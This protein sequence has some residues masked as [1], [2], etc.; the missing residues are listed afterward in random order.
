MDLRGRLTIKIISVIILFFFT[1]TFGGVFDIAY[2]VKDSSQ[3][4]ASGRQGNPVKQQ[5][6]PQKPE[7]KLQKAIEAIE[8]AI[9]DT[10]IDNDKKKNRLV[11]KKAEIE[12]LDKEI[13]KQFAETEKKLKEKGLP[14]EI[15]ERHYKF[16]RNYEDNLKELNTNLDAVNKHDAKSREFE[17]AIKKTKE[18]LAK[19]KLPSKHKRLDPNKLPHRTADPVFK[20]P[21]TKPE[22]FQKDSQKAKVAKGQSKPILVASSGSLD[23]LLGQRAYQG[24]PAPTMLAMANPPTSDDLAQTIEVQFT[25]AIKA[26]AAELNYNPVK[27][28]NW[29]RNNIEYVP[30]YGSI[31]GADMCLQTKQCND[32][33]T[34]SLLIALLRASGI[35]A[36]YVYGTIEL[37]IDK[38]KNWIGGFTDNNAAL[39]LIASGGIPIKGFTSGGSIASAQM[40]HVWVEAWIDYI[41][42]RGA[43]HKIGNTWIPLDAS[44]KQFT[45]KQGID[46]KSITG[47][48]PKS[49]IDGITASSTADPTTGSVTNVPTS[50]IQNQMDTMVNSLNNYI[51]T[52]MPDATVRDILGGKDIVQHNYRILPASLPFQ[53]VIADNRFSQAPNSLRHNIMITIEDP[54]GIDAPLSYSASLPQLSSKRLTLGYMP[55][56]AA[57]AQTLSTYGYY[58][59]PLYLVN[60]KPVLYIDGVAA[61]QGASLG[62]GDT[63]S[64]TITFSQPGRE[65]DSVMHLIAASTFASIGLDT[66]RIPLELLTDRKAKLD[67]TLALMGQQDVAVDDVIGEILNLHS[68]SYF[69]QVELMN[70]IA[71]QGKIAYAK[72]TLEMFITLSPNI[73]YLYGV[74]YSVAGL[75]MNVDAKRQ[76]VTAISLTGNNDEQRNFMLMT[77]QYAS[78]MEH[79][80]FEEFN[81]DAQGVSA[82][83]IISEAVKQGIPIY[84][85]TADNID[86]ILPRLQISSDALDD[87]KNAVA[88]GKKV[89]IP[90]KSLQY[91]DWSGDG[92]IIINPP[93]GAGAYM[94]AGGLSGGGLAT[95]TDVQ[96]GI[97]T[98]LRDISF[99]TLQTA[100]GQLLDEKIS[101]TELAG[102]LTTS[103][104]AVQKLM[105]WAG[106]LGTVINSLFAWIDIS[107]AT[108]NI[109][110]AAAAFIG[111]LLLGFAATATLAWLV[112]GLGVITTVVAISA[113]AILSQVLQSILMQLIL[114][115]WLPLRRCFIY[116]RNAMAV[117]YA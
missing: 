55:A 44:Y 117:G 100:F 47:F 56:T 85:I 75:G 83:K 92:Y 59:T 4:K 97:N 102:D 104:A 62:M 50:Q 48:D 20:E 49:F 16:V 66:Q 58:N 106:T 30:T 28:Y 60:L 18:H 34:A 63:Q 12:S 14:A 13:K 52:N 91:Y 65:S 103:L 10:K 43:S 57:D 81:Q 27:I 89:Y 1:W 29:V 2:A 88:A 86:T 115:A 98:L 68:L 24:D 6:Q 84:E 95:F 111:T 71:S 64:L 9:S 5:P 23:G 11:S 15:L 80:I 94:I 32:M 77:G 19:V 116:K 45:Y 82:V 96:A 51:N 73:S 53:V 72:K 54:Y 112:P 37:P 22:E 101:A 39:T 67:Q 35:S 25:D 17:E 70:R 61:A 79:T 38:V 69:Y 36:R 76:I 41:P 113:V 33:D 99:A 114:T 40:E 90:E 105:K 3:N 42:S 87:I 78:A 108:H 31:Q 93:T 46:V 74:P 26:K 109:W 21:R 8:Q 7:E 110:K 107:N